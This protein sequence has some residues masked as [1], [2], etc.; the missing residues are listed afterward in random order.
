MSLKLLADPDA[1]GATG[2]GTP[3]P[4]ARV[5]PAR[6]A[7][8]RR[9]C[10]GSAANWA[11]SVADQMQGDF[12]AV[13]RAPV[14]EQIDPLPGAQRQPAIPDRDGEL[15]AGQGRAEMRGHVVGAF[16]RVPISPRLLRRQAVENV[17]RSARTL[18]AAFS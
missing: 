5:A 15:H 7:A 18:S 13:G 8:K 14:L 10:G 17:S 2:V 4:G 12:P 3:V 6:A 9:L 16:V 11:Q 1:R